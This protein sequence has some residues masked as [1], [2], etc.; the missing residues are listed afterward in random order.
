MCIKQQ[1]R[2]TLLTHLR[3]I[4]HTSPEKAPAKATL[5]HAPLVRRNVNVDRGSLVSRRDPR[6]SRNIGAGGSPIYRKIGDGVPNFTENWGRGS[7]ISWDPQFY[8]TPVLQPF[9]RLLVPAL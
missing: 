7:L 5:L 9:C 4:E 6:F 2:L 1:S 8:V 3:C